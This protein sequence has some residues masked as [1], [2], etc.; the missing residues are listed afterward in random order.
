MKTLPLR[1]LTWYLTP[2]NGTFIPSGLPQCS[3]TELSKVESVSLLTC[4]Q[5][6]VIGTNFEDLE[7]TVMGWK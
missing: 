5:E 4:E 3:R 2:N 6:S 7:G 1:H